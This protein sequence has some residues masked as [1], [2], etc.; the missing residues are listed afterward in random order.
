MTRAVS[1]TLPFLCNFRST[2]DEH[3][4][5][6]AGSLHDCSHVSNGADICHSALNTFWLKRPFGERLQVAQRSRLS[7]V[8]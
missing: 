8:G 2:E 6:P 1:F 4:G 3:R 7:S 5:Y